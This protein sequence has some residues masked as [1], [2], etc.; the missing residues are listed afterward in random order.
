MMLIWLALPAVILGSGS[1][2]LWSI[3]KHELPTL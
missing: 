1:Y 2:V 3:H